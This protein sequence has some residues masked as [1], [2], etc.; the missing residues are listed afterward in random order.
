MNDWLDIQ[1]VVKLT[2]TMQPLIWGPMVCL[3]LLMLARSPVI[4]DWD[5]PWGLILVLIVMVLYAI[6]AEVYLQLGAKMVRKKAIEQLT[7]KIK[8][9]RN[10]TNPNNIVIKR[11]EDEVECIR[12]LSE[13]AFRP[14]YQWPLLQAFGGLSA[15]VV[16]LEQYFS[17]LL[18]SRSF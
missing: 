15:F 5:F 12:N 16:A 9:Q 17:W 3:A 1:L 8:V 6:S 4:D 10:G 11:I 7:D 18:Q 14:W 2:K 13:G